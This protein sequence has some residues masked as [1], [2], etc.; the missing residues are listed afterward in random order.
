[1]VKAHIFMWFNLDRNFL[2]GII[3]YIFF[4]MWLC[5]EKGFHRSCH[6][7]KVILYDL[8]KNYSPVKFHT[9][10]RICRTSVSGKL[11]SWCTSSVCLFILQ[12][13]DHHHAVLAYHCPLPSFVNH[14]QH[15]L[16]L[17]FQIQKECSEN[18]FFPQS[19]LYRNLLSCTGLQ[20]CR[21]LTLVKIWHLIILFML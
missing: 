14:R 12:S 4:C 16:C 9:K 17:I 15:P 6:A 1:M 8:R 13:H 5:G 7:A 19:K 2:V 10:A 20:F 11:P 18:Y 3:I 21:N